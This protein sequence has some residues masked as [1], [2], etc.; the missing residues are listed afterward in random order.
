[1]K[2]AL[3]TAANVDVEKLDDRALA[4]ALTID[5]HVDVTSPRWDEPSLSPSDWAA[6]DAVC[7]R[8]CWDYHLR[9][10]EFIDW[11]TRVDRA[12]VRWINPAPGMRWN[13]HKRYLIDLLND[14]IPVAPLRLIPRGSHS[15]A[16]GDLQALLHDT[17]WPE[18]IVKPA[19]SASA[20]RTWRT[21]AVTPEVSRERLAE[22]LADSDAIVQ[23]FVPEIVD[24][25]W[26]L[27]FVENEMSHAVRK[28]PRAGDF[29]TQSEL[30][31]AMTAE[32][33][34]ASLVATARAALR[35]ASR[36]GAPCLTRL[37]LVE[38]AEGPVVMEVELIEPMLF[39]AYAPGSAARA[40]SALVAR[41][42]AASAAI[43]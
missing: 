30:G 20:Y 12:G 43:G 13:S 42:R 5:H 32:Q 26:S 29:R 17:G 34:P 14:G 21:S 2:I 16:D 37:D 7:L 1:M 27:V 6:F 23:R 40:A 10:D 9:Y 28:R 18:A 22:L 33:P 3:V 4:D 39:F 41:M 31:A 25:E 19:I 15:A 8:S 35:S 11:F 38:T 36:F 24:G